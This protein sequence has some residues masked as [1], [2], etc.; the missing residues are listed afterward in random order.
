MK[1]PIPKTEESA[2]V[3]IWRVLNEEFNGHAKFAISTR[4]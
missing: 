1:F 3:E 2:E 4:N